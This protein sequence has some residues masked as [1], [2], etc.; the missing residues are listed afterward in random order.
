MFRDSKGFGRL[1]GELEAGRSAAVKSRRDK[2]TRLRPGKG[3]GGYDKIFGTGKENGTAVGVEFRGG[4][5]S[6][7][8]AVAARVVG[9]TKYMKVPGPGGREREGQAE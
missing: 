4:N 7:D 6:A 9:G 8:P 1:L 3:R 2:G 5:D